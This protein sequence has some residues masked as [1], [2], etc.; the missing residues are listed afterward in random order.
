MERG[1]GGIMT[2]TIGQGSY[3]QFEQFD[4]YAYNAVKYLMDNDEIIWKLLKYNDPEAWDKPDLT[5]EQKA[6]LIYDGSDN[7][8][9]FRV[10][11]DQGQP[12]VNVG[13]NTQIRISQ[14]SLFP[15]NR[16]IATNSMMFEVYTH[17]K[18]NHL[19]NYKTRAD[20]IMKR[21]LQVFNGCP[22]IGGI[23]NLYF[24]RQASESA[25]Q[26]YGGQLPYRGKWV[27]MSNKSN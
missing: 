15:E 1:S 25:R 14:Y 3:A 18:I 11:L 4:E 19:S 8:A 17:Y 24:D 2:N 20:M 5:K 7:T 12:D 13:E 22:S 26:E 23:G 10:F 21:F 27:V 16:T 9:L 6:A